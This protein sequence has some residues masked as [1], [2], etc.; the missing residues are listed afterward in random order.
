MKILLFG[1]GGQVGWELSRC[2]LPLGEMV[3]LDFPEADFSRPESLRDMVSRVRPD[4]IVNAAAHTA[5]DPA[6]KEEEL[7][8]R[9]NADAPAVLAE[10]ATRCGA[11]LVHYSTDYVFDGTGDEPYSESD[12][13][14]PLSA[15]GR[16]KLK[17][18]CAIQSSQADHLIFRTSWV[19]SS[20]GKNFL[21]SI[22]R[23]AAEREELRIVSDQHGAPT[24][25]RLIADVTA[26]ALRQAMRERSEG[27]FASGIFNLVSSGTTN[28]LGFAGA[29]IAEARRIGLKPAPV[30][31]RIVPVSTAEYAAAAPR[32]LN[33][34]LAVDR[35]QE[36]FG[37]VMPDWRIGMERCI[38]ECKL[39]QQ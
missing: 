15:Y 16:S 17:G 1:R 27:S 32:P 34:A 39:L 6:E 26:H 8:T 29:I 21:R 31:E 33:S 25:A 12:A 19:Y 3:A 37:L 24:W 28:W 38:D 2:L 22:L 35:I 5:V 11:L 4:V 13:P 10:E 20:H 36:R 18:D 9:I 30:V 14:N 23:L 7:A